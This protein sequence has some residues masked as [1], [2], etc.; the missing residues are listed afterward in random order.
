[1]C[2]DHLFDDVKSE[3]CARGLPGFLISNTVKFFKDRFFFGVGNALPLVGNAK[4]ELSVFLMSTED[5]LS[6]RRRIF[7]GI[8]EQVLNDGGESWF[9]GL[10]RWCIFGRIDADVGMRETDTQV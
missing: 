1:M 10:H 4:L 7:N 9:I 2:F 6:T 3:A 5:H 8:F